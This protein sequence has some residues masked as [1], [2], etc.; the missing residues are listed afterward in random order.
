MRSLNCFE[1]LLL[2][3]YI[4]DGIS[5]RTRIYTFFVYSITIMYTTFGKIILKAMSKDIE[6]LHIIRIIKGVEILIRKYIPTYVILFKNLVGNIYLC[7]T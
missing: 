1:E 6:L 3:Y 4:N 2:S 5:Y 7:I